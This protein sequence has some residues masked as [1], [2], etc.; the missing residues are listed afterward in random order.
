MLSGIRIE[1]PGTADDAKV[2]LLYVSRLGQLGYLSRNP[3]W[4][5]WDARVAR[6]IACAELARDSA[7]A[8]SQNRHNLRSGLPA[9]ADK[10]RVTTYPLA[11]TED[12]HY[13]PHSGW[14]ALILGGD[15]FHRISPIV[16][17]GCGGLVAPYVLDLP[18]EL[19][20]A[21][22]RWTVHHEHLYSLWLASDVY[23]DWALR[24]LT[25]TASRLNVQA[26]TLASDL[27]GA[28][29]VKVLYEPMSPADEPGG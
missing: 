26:G 7:W 1:A 5:G 6:V 4:V 19:A 11:F 20:G 2:W 13:C 21:L 10:L 24:E 18:A 15:E 29:G 9:A 14:D 17:E 28:L 16:H 23:E 8:D 27:Q 3:P 22:W 12:E 25:E